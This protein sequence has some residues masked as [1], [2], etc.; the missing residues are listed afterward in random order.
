MKRIALTIAALTI[1]A[2]L[3]AP[4]AGASRFDGQLVKAQ[5]SLAYYEPS[6]SSWDLPSRLE[7]NHVPGAKWIA[8]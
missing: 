6:D 3:A 4:A 2:A 7:R 1:V 5:G 8:G